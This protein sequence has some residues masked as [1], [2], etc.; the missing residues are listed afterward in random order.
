MKK[1]IYLL[2]VFYCLIL[3]LPLASAVVRA[4]ANA[5]TVTPAS[6]TCQRNMKKH[7]QQEKKIAHLERFLERF[8][9]VDM[10]D[11]T[12]KWLYLSIFTF[13]IAILLQLLYKAI[14][15]SFIISLANTFA[16]VAIIFFVVWLIKKYA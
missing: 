4:P 10:S 16:V 7:F 13:V 2:P 1:I 8:Y 3:S 14:L 5:A 6:K 11:H 12:Q 15:F 9:S